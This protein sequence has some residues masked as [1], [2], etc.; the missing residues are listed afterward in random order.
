M[1][2]LRRFTLSMTALACVV[3]T[4]H[5]LVALEWRIETIDK[6]TAISRNGSLALDST[7]TAHAFYFA[8]TTVPAP[9][10]GGFLEPNQ[11]EL[12]HATR[13]AGTWEV[14][15][16]ETYLP[17]PGEPVAV[18][19][20]RVDAVIDETGEI[21]VAYSLVSPHEVVRYAHLGTDGWHV[22]QV[23]PPQIRGWG[24]A[25]TVD[26]NQNPQLLFSD[27]GGLGAAGYYATRG[28]QEWDLQ[29]IRSTD[30]WD[31]F[32][33]SAGEIDSA[34][35]LHAVGENAGGAAYAV[36]RDGHW[37][38]ESLGGASRNMDITLDELDRPHIAW[39]GL[40]T[41]E[42]VYSVRGG[43]NWDHTVL[44]E[45]GQLGLAQISITLD[46]L[47]NPHLGFETGWD[48]W[49]ETF[50]RYVYWNGTEWSG[51]TVG[52]GEVQS[53]RSGVSLAIDDR[54]HPHLLFSD[55][56]SHVLYAT[57]VPEPSSL[58]LLCLGL[59]A[60]ILAGRRCR[61]GLA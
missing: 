27:N 2:S 13:R 19:G 24:P 8:P 34:G 46:V 56:Q 39:V 44:E 42:L 10:A 25:L 20:D 55:D 50:L 40:S 12:R 31:H 28:E 53:A 30:T 14:S 11:L 58:N 38:F 16:I 26:G 29:A 36:R 47:D 9:D 59:V 48:D 57:P 7:G 18:P 23:H 15:T 4:S 35:A 21:H 49:R 33:A 1:T 60:T 41:G 61:A 17:E 43:N 52:F 37:R 45:V 54:L 22:E 3:S 32:H 5:S 6:T 51:D